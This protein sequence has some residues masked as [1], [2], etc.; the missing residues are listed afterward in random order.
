MSCSAQAPLTITIK[1]SL[2][3]IYKAN[4]AI[5]TDGIRKFLVPLWIIAFIVFASVGFLFTAKAFG[6]PVPIG[7]AG[8]W[9]VLFVP[10]FLLI[11]CY[12]TPYF[13][14]RSSY[15]NS[16]NLQNPIHYSFSDEVIAQEMATGRAELLWSTFIKVRETPDFFLLFVQKH[17]ANPVPKRDFENEQEIARFRELLRC[18]VRDASLL[19]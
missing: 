17:L 4:V 14:A 5:T 16:L 12:V 9:G 1:L 18:H 8:L 10:T 15:R 19:G 3:D 6:W 13:G 11:I 7:M 2:R